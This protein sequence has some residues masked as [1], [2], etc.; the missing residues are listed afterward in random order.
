MGK[1][2]ERA[3]ALALV[4]L[5]PLAC[6]AGPQYPLTK[7]AAR[8][9]VMTGQT[10]RP[11]LRLAT[12]QGGRTV[13]AAQFP[14]KD[15]GARI[16]AADA[17]LGAQAGTIILQGGGNVST[18]VHVS[19]KHT[20]QLASGTYTAT[21][22]GPP[23]LLDDDTAMV[24]DDWGPIIKESTAGGGE[25][26]FKV[27]AAYKGNSLAYPNGSADTHN[28][29]VQGLHIVGARPDFGS[30]GAA[31]D[32]GDCHSCQIKHN[33]LDHTRSIGINTGGGNGTFIQGRPPRYY[34]QD[35]LVV[36]NLL[37]GV[38]SQNIGIVNTQRA[39]ILNNVIRAPGQPGGPGCDPIDVEPNVGDLLGAVTIAGNTIDAS[40]VTWLTVFDAIN[41]QNTNDAQPYGPVEVRANK[42]IG[43]QLTDRTDRIIFS[44]I[45]TTAVHGGPVL[46]KDNTVYRVPRGIYIA[47]WSTGV[48]VEDNQLIGTGGGGGVYP[49][50]VENSTHNRISNNTASIEAGNGIYDALDFGSKAG[51][52]VINHTMV[53][54][55]SS[56]YN[57]FAHNHGRVVL[58]GPHSSSNGDAPDPTPQ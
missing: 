41:V 29:L 21:T 7:V 38:A 16:N 51:Y 45:R 39:Q 2:K 57:T 31:I 24:A 27:V 33:Y 14:G 1:R 9:A 5:L 8:P 26:Q 32:I 23:F 19:P 53:E 55:G 15:V 40:T 49:I 50:L 30:A 12:Q 28:I 46:I 48:T 36:D 34:S 6:L 52:I 17:A 11:K 18:Q 58:I 54:A 13:Y 42:I 22:T 37:V 25:I 56:D 44:G 20:L 47:Y 35:V 3:R 43:A 4:I 10:S